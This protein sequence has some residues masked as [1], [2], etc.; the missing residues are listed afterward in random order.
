MAPSSLTLAG[1]A[2]A[3]GFRERTRQ[4]R[5]PLRGPTSGPT[6]GPTNNTFTTSRT[7]CSAKSSCSSPQHGL[8][9]TEWSAT[10][11]PRS[12]TLA[13]FAPAAGFH[14]RTRQ[15]RGP[16]RGPTSGPTNNTFTTGKVQTAT[17]SRTPC[18]AESSWSSL[19]HRLRTTEWSATMAPRSLTSVGFAPVA[20]FRERTRQSRGPLRGPTSGPTSGPTNTVF[21]T[22]KVQTATTSRTPCSAESSCSSPQHGLR[23][24]EWSATMAP[25]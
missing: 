15:S 17:T 1:F 20:G 24:T 18:S 5:G 19:Q 9:T 12:L 4:S 22:G 25:R 11:A 23:T 16:L 6:S 13:G 2:P 8:R 14:E 10:M 21:I 7:P 3:A